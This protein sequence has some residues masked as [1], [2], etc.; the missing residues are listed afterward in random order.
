MPKVIDSCFVSR[1]YDFSYI[2]KKQKD[3]RVRAI[4]VAVEKSFCKL[5]YAYA[6]YYHLLPL[7][8]FI[9][10]PHYLIKDTIFEK[11]VIDH[12]MCFYFLCTFVLKF[13]I[14]RRIERDMMKMYIG[15]QAK[16]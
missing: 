11:K 9:I 16:H 2:F 8:L 13:L 12:K 6:P 14:L 1:S 4:T 5:W 10:F 15:V 7:R 3:W